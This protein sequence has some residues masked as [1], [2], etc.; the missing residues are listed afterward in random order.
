MN[1]LIEKFWTDAGYEVM[2]K[3]SNSNPNPTTGD[4]EWRYAWFIYKNSIYIGLIGSAL[5]IQAERP[6]SVK[7]DFYCFDGGLHSEKDMLK[8]IKLKA[9]I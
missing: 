4:C 3:K 9:F 1:P 8:I 6:K 5:V 7:C 2:S